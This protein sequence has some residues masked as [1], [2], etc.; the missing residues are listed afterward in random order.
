MANWRYRIELNAALAKAND[1][2]DL[3]RHE[4]KCPESVL[5][6]VASEIEK[7]LPLARFGK[8]IR[9]AKSIAEFNRILS[10]IYDEADR[11]LV[12]CGL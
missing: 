2:F 12:W 3:S 5:I 10:N 1:E 9:K 11:S 8:K 4:E 6:A 7:A